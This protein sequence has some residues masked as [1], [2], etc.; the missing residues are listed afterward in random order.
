[1]P[2]GPRINLKSANEH[3][4]YI[5]LQIRVVK[6]RTR[7]FRHSLLFSNIS[8]L[9]TVYIV[10]TAVNMINYLPVKVEASSILST[11]IIL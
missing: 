5:E 9:L 11:K 8:N 3:V 2:G 4:P 10:F 6:E 1:M 7:T